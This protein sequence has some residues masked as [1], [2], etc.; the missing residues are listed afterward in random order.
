MKTP[1]GNCTLILF[2]LFPLAPSSFKNFLFPGLLFEG[3]SII[4]LPVKYCAVNY[5]FVFCKSSGFP[6]KVISP[7]YLPAPGPISKT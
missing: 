1:N 5:F 3:I 4:L 2:K 7:P 6:E